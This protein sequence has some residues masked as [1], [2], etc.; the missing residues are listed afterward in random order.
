M[1]KYNNFLD[2][3]KKNNKK[4]LENTLITLDGKLWYC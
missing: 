3:R 2:K 1:V 4:K